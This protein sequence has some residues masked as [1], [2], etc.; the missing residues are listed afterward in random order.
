MVLNCPSRIL[1]VRVP[2]FRLLRLNLY[3]SFSTSRLS[4]CR[5]VSGSRMSVIK[6]HSLLRLGD[7]DGLGTADLGRPEAIRDSDEAQGPKLRA[8]IS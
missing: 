7:F 4:S 6:V 2:A 3:P 5:I 1:T 8:S